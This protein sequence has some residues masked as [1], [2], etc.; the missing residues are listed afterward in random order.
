MS[1][2]LA[3]MRKLK[4]P[5]HD[6]PEDQRYLPSLGR[7]GR[8]SRELAAEMDRL[9]SLGYL[10]RPTN[11]ASK[12]APA[13]PKAAPKVKTPAAPAKA[14]KAAEPVEKA[15]R[16]RSRKTEQEVDN[17]YSD[18]IQTLAE[19]LAR[20]AKFHA[21]GKLGEGSILTVA[22]VLAKAAI[23]QAQEVA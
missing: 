3:T 4:K 11:I 19:N 12:T 22:R 16:R 14:E 17:G 10:K 5:V 6:L 23:R 1:D 18:T 15:P 20:M 8:P 21:E 2:V 9:K 13:K 7:R